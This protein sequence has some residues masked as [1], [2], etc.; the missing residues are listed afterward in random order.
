V[1]LP[2]TISA[3]ASLLSFGVVAIVTPLVKYI[4]S[5][6][7]KQI[8]ELR[9]L[10]EEDNRNRKGSD[11]RVRELELKVTRFE[12]EVEMANGVHSRMDRMTEK[13]ESLAREVSG[14]QS[15]FNLLAKGR[16]VSV[17]SP[18]GETKEGG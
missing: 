14:M 6:K 15:T 11:D 4:V 13:L 16:L 9:H 2:T 17:P 8:E 12:G 1:D 7:D 10:I 3:F 5:T 18:R